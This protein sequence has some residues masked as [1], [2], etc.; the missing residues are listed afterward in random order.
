MRQ[1]HPFLFLTSWKIVPLKI[2][3]WNWFMNS[4]PNSTRFEVMLAV[5]HFPGWYLE[6]VAAWSKAGPPGNAPANG[7]TGL[8]G[9]GIPGK[10]WPLTTW[11]QH[12]YNAM[13]DGLPLSSREICLRLRECGS[14]L[15]KLVSQETRLLSNVACPVSQESLVPRKKF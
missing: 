13:T 7:A 1:W 5:R 4:L 10:N 6:S 2:A 8:V 14:A 9:G 12:Q 15:R 11:K 3:M